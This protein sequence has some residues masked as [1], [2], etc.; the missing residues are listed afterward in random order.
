MFV[1]EP[2]AAQSPFLIPAS[3][4]VDKKYYLDGATFRNQSVCEGKK[5]Q[6]NPFNFKVEETEPGE[7]KTH[8]KVPAAAICTQ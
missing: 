6:P 7:C 5:T 4:G 3:P 8:N 2:K 1:L